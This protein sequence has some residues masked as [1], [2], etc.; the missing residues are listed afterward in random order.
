MHA[1]GAGVHFI[2][3][4]DRNLR[5]QANESIIG[6]YDEGIVMMMYDSVVIKRQ[7]RENEI[8]TDV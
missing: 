2:K 8:L 7:T 4:I 5:G 3:L 6:Q 1:Y